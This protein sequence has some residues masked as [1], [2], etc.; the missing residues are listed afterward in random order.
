MSAEPAGAAG[1][2]LPVLVL[3]GML[4]DAGLWS[5][6]AF[7]EGHEIRHLPLTEPDIGRQADRVLGAVPGPFVLAGHSLGAIVGFEVVRRAPDRVAGLCVM[8]TNAGAPRAGQYAAWRELD[9][10][11]AGGDFTEA[12][13][14]TL[15]GMFG[16]PRP[17]P[18]RAERYRRM[19]CAVGPEAARAQLAAQATRTDALAALRTADCPA[20]VLHGTRDALCPPSFHAAITAALPRGQRREVEGA[21]HLLPWERPEAV[22]TALRDLLAEAETARR[23]PAG[24]PVRTPR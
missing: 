2:P 22:S 6:V 17:G 4:C 10:L 24:P 15:P 5:E 14:R 8:S 7:P 20:V 16:S 23:T 1:T 19:A 21:G 9:A 13:E 18:A 12:V 3:S 11:I